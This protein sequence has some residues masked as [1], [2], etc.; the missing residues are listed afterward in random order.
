VPES[1]RKLTETPLKKTEKPKTVEAKKKA[2]PK[3]P[4][5]RVAEQ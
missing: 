5:D 2:P 1:S 4:K 3:K